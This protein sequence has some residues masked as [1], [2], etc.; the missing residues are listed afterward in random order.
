MVTSDAGA[1][2]H[3]TPEVFKSPY[4]SE[5]IITSHTSY[6]QNIS[7]AISHHNTIDGNRP[8]GEV[9]ETVTHHTAEYVIM[10]TITKPAREPVNEVII[11]HERS[12]EQ[13]M[14]FVCQNSLSK[15]GYFISQ[16]INQNSQIIN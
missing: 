10:R 6:H 14:Q 2:T 8:Y 15:L 16:F 5:H 11:R 7:E 1:T 13:T 4:I 12:R 3:H 9:S